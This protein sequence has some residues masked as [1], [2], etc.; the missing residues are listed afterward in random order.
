MCIP[1]QEDRILW[2]Q[3]ITTRDQGTFQE[4]SIVHGLVDVLDA[5]CTKCGLR[6]TEWPVVW[7]L[8]IQRLLKLN[9]FVRFCFSV[10][11][12]FLSEGLYSLDCV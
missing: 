9:D 11:H 4:L 2:S 12:H 6:A 10:F 7:S 1:K 5:K 8:K 3:V